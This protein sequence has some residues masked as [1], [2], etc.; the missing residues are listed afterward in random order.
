LLNTWTNIV[1]AAVALV[2][3]LTGR[4]LPL[5]CR[6]IGLMRSFVDIIS[7]SGDWHSSCWYRRLWC[8]VLQTHICHVVDNNSTSIIRTVTDMT[9]E[10]LHSS[11]RRSLNIGRDVYLIAIDKRTVW[12]CGR[13]AGMWRMVESK[14]ATDEL[15]STAAGSCLALSHLVYTWHCSMTSTSHPH[16]HQ[17][18]QQ[19]QQQLSL[20]GCQ[21]LTN[22]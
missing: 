16:P 8:P 5:Y 13:T 22:W 7:P 20:T 11:R 21:S 17:Q 12:V 19:Q 2:D 18:Q 3:R 6:P 4:R 14:W 9:C 10:H 15:D 1:S